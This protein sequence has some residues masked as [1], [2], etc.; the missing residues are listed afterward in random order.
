MRPVV[1]KN[2]SSKSAPTLPGICL[3]INIIT[4]ENRVLKKLPLEGFEL[5][6]RY[7]K[8]IISVNKFVVILVNIEN[9]DADGFQAVFLH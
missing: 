7:T 6:F 4:E 9:L 5:K 1:S 2:Q 8:T 3:K